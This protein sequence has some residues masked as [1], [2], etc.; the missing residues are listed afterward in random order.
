MIR[1]L[2]PRRAQTGVIRKPPP[3]TKQT[4]T[5]RRK[6]A[7]LSHLMQNRRRGLKRGSR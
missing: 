1:F 5:A 7:A 2:S 4:E 6:A 3:V